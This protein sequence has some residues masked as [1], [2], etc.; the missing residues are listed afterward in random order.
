MPETPPPDAPRQVNRL[1]AV[2][3]VVGLLALVPSIVVYQNV[4]VG[5]GRPDL[6]AQEPNIFRAA[7]LVA[8]TG[9][10]YALAL[11][12]CCLTV[13]VAALGGGV[14][15]VGMR[16]SPSR[17]AVAGVVVNVLAAALMI[18]LANARLS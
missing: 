11:T 1:G 12:T 4:P 6:F 13:L 17:Q 16:R 15:V 7:A 18:V 2:S 10:I 5:I 14:G 3:L 8:L 9:S